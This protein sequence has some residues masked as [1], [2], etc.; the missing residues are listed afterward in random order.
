M[1]RVAER[2]HPD[3]IALLAQ[4]IEADEAASRDGHGDAPF[5]VLL[6]NNQITLLDHPGLLPKRPA[7]SRRAVRGLRSAGL[8]EVDAEGSDVLVVYLAAGARGR[9]DEARQGVD[10]AEPARA[11]DTGPGDLP[12]GLTW[13]EIEGAYRRLVAEAPGFRCRRRR[14]GEPSRPEL[15]AALNVSPATLKRACAAAGEG[16]RWPPI[17]LRPR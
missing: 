9:L 5:R 10:G 4:M 1:W 6:L 3:A 7:I 15:A 14:P 12:G 17:R 11:R 8:F 2:L 13:D 16:S